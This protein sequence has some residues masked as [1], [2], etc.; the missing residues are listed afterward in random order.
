MQDDS[1]E[2]SVSSLVPPGS[3]GDLAA[4]KENSALNENNNT[5][6]QHHNTSNSSEDNSE[7]RAESDMGSAKGGQSWT[8]NLVPAAAS[9]H[10]DW[11]IG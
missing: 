3:N 9:L 1:L 10:G 2:G 6:L 11:S 4:K 7:G 5:I 8:G